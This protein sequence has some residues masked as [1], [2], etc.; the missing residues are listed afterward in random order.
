MGSYYAVHTSPELPGVQLEGQFSGD[1][2]ISASGGTGTTGAHH[3]PPS[4]LI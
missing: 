4:Y 3:S 1:P 2:S